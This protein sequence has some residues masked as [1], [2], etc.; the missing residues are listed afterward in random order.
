MRLDNLMCC[1]QVSSK[2]QRA[3]R[4]FSCANEI[5]KESRFEE[6]KKKQCERDKE[7][8]GDYSIQMESI[9]A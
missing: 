6:E 4:I 2:N 7:K 8:N 9:S 1:W 3:N 5:V